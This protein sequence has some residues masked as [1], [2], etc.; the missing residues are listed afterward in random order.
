MFSD[1]QGVKT[2]AKQDGDDYIINGSK[3]FITNGFSS[4]VAIVVT[5]TKTEGKA[6]QGTSLIILEAT[7]KG[8]HKG[9]NLNKLGL[10]GAVSITEDF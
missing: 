4:D 1:L 8:F 9:K 2:Y 5:K 7:D 10:K 6:S 3:V